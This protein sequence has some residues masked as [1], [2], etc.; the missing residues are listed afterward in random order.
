MFIVIIAIALNCLG[1]SHNLNTTG[2][3]F[4]P[5]R[6]GIVTSN[7][8]SRSDPFSLVRKFHSGIDIAAPAGS[9]IWPIALGRVSFSGKYE[10]FGNLVVVQHG[11][12]ISTHYAHCWAV[13]VKV[14]DLVSKET[15]L[16]FVGQSGRATGPHVHFEVRYKGEAVNPMWLLK[17]KEEARG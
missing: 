6:E 11:E 3:Y 4:L 14:G 7:Y 17:N 15:V 1:L 9:K 13:R 12:G 2:N 16:G 8:G 10:G 5:V